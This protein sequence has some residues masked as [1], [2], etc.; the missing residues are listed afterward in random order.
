MQVRFSNSGPDQ[1]LFYSTLRNRVDGY[2]SDNNISKHCNTEMV[3][4]TIV[5]LL[6]YVVPFLALISFHPSF[7]ISLV[8]WAFMGLSAAGVGM[9]VMHDANHGAYSKN[10]TVNFW[11]GGTLNLMGGSIFNWKMQHNQLHHTYTNIHD[12]DDDIDPKAFM[13]FSPHSKRRWYHNLQFVYAFFF[14]GVLTLYW[15]ILKDFIQFAKYKKEG[16]NK[17]TAAE[18]KKVMLNMVITKVL[19]M[20][21]FIVLPVTVFALPFWQV[22]GGF[23]LMHFVAGIVLTVVFQLA[24][25]VEGTTH[26][27]PDSKGSIENNW[28]VHQMNTTVNFSRRNRWLSWYVGGLNFQVEHH[29]FPTICHVHYPHIAAIVKQTAEESGVPYLENITFWNA[30]HSHIRTLKRF[31]GLPQINEAIA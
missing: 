12:M 17:N 26:P 7:A 20:G 18:N 28:A 30:L 6:A 14:Y 22:I 5:L 9:S 13:R 1:T 21:I 23:L 10:K 29:L 27:L 2:F 19:Y 4:K 25:T 3:V 31:G 16:L 24:H 11:L 15:A 8:L